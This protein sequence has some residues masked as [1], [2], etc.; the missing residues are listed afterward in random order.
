MKHCKLTTERRPHAGDGGI[1]S[2]GDKDGHFQSDNNLW[3][4]LFTL[5]T[6]HGVPPRKFALRAETKEDAIGCNFASCTV[7][8]SRHAIV[9]RELQC[10]RIQCT[11][12]GTHWSHCADASNTD[13]E[14]SFTSVE[15]FTMNKME[16]F[17]IADETALPA[18]VKKC[19][20]GCSFQEIVRDAF[21]QSG[22]QL[23][24][25]EWQKQTSQLS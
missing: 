7:F 12:I 4:F 24:T 15:E 1:T 22:Q 14:V 3:S 13:F 5:R 23:H 18:N 6:P 20:S 2:P 21:V 9:V 11:T 8:G 19:A 25:S 17:E 10:K 16:I